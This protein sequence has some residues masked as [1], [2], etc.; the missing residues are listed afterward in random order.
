M[1]QS[2]NPATGEVL[3][4]FDE[5]GPQQIEDALARAHA[6]FHRH[7][8]TSL[9][10]RGA[11]LRRAGEIMEHDKHAL[12]TL[13]TREMGKTLKSAIAEAEKCAW[14]CRYY[15]E[16]AERQL[17]DEVLASD[18]ARSYTRCLPLGPVLAVMPWNFPFW[19]V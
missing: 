19:Q 8:R 5:I 14:V 3:A 1:I 13:M 2:K 15:A 7:R 6:A 17:A 10:E 12:A 9:P 11:A 16:H 18:A 4:Q